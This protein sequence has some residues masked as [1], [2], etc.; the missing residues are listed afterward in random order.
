MKTRTGHHSVTNKYSRTIKASVPETLATQCH[1]GPQ[2]FAPS[3]Q[4]HT[5]NRQ[6]FTTSRILNQTISQLDTPKTRNNVGTPKRYGPQNGGDL[7]RLLAAITVGKTLHA[8]RRHTADKR[9]V[10]TEQSSAGD[11]ALP[12]VSPQS[13]AREPTADEA[14]ALVEETETAMRQLSP[15]QRQVLQLRL[16]GYTF[17]QTAAMAGCSE[18]TVRRVMKL[19]KTRLEEQLLKDSTGE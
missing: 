9:S 7:W 16:Q 10:Y 13:I 19:V 1:T 17:D 4:C 2:S 8:V 6:T 3:I 11:L 5:P 14:A 18:R 12:T 15:L